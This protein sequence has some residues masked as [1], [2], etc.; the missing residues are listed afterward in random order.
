MSENIYPTPML[1]Q[2]ILF[3]C[4]WIVVVALIYG[5]R[6]VNKIQRNLIQIMRDFNEV[7]QSHYQVLDKYTEAA[8]IKARQEAAESDESKPDY[9]RFGDTDK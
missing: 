8:K 3:L 2:L 7:C 6:V 9:F 4:Q 1:N 5:L